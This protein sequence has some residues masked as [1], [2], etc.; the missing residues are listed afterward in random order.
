[1]PY[2]ETLAQRIRKVVRRRKEFVEKKRFGGVGFLLDGNMCVG[3]WKNSLVVR[4][5]REEHEAALALEH[6][7][8]FD[9]TGRAIKGWALVDPEGIV[10]DEVVGRFCSPVE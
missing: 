7:R 4:F 2:D 9:I 10:S 1:V 3:V 5:D 6:V 8:P